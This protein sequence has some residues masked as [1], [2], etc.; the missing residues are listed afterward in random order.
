MFESGFDTQIRAFR[1]ALTGIEGVIGCVLLVILL[2]GVVVSQ[3]AKWGAIAVMLWMST[4]SFFV[5][6][7]EVPIPLAQPLDA[8]RY[9]GR[10][11][12]VVLLGSLIVPTII[13]SRGWRQRLVGIGLIAYF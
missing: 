11:I 2:V 1:D 3:R 4:F 9:Y 12:T 7:V 6:T 8:M 5:A 10:P 13:S